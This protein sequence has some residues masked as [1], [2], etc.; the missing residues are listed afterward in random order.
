MLSSLGVRPQVYSPIAEIVETDLRDSAFLNPAS[1]LQ[2]EPEGQDKRKVIEVEARETDKAL[3]EYLACD[4]LLRRFFET[5]LFERDVPA[6]DRRSD[7]VYL[8]EVGN[9][10]LYLGLFGDEYGWENKDGLSPTHLEY[11][12][13]TQLGK[14]RLI[15]V[16]GANDDAKDPKMR[17]L[18]RDAGHASVPHNALLAEPMY[19]AKYIERMG[20]GIRG[21]IR[22]CRAAGLPEPEIRLDGGSFVLTIRRKAAHSGT[23]SRP[24]WD[25]GGSKSRP[26]ADPVHRKRPGFA[27]GAGK[28]RR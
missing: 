14:A 22:R 7:A 25:Q 6:S 26:S 2:S 10:D 5:F 9:C 13:A 27:G 20:T 21:M 18:L 28:E 8:D 1:K 24:T 16:K 3:A 15:F 17:V 19:L 23:D 4:P 12:E 11:N